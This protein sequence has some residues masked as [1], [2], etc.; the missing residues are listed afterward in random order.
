MYQKQLQMGSV[1]SLR[2]SLS[3]EK[4]Q[5]GSHQSRGSVPSSP[6]FHIFQHR[7]KV[8]D[9]RLRA[10]EGQLLLEGGHLLP[11]RFVQKCLKV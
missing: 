8:L 7:G 6:V 9:A 5:E 10:L 1:L 11:T 4:K 3:Y 2:I